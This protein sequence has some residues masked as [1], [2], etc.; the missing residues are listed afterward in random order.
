MTHQA[1]ISTTDK[2]QDGNNIEAAV[3]MPDYIKGRCALAHIYA[4]DG[5]YHSATRVLLELA[6]E[7]KAHAVRVHGGF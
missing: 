4:E 2:D 5:A 6:D 1:V 3:Y 7:V